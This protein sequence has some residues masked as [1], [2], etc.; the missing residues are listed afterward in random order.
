MGKDIGLFKLEH[1]GEVAINSYTY[2][3]NTDFPVYR[4]IPKSRFKKWN[5]SHD[6]PWDLLVDPLPLDGN[7]YEY[8]IT[9][10]RLKLCEEAQNS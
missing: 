6:R 3:W 10:R 1:S 8:S 5:E 7:E 2:Q 4:S 9:E